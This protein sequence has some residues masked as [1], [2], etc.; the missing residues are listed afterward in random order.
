MNRLIK[1]LVIGMVCLPY[2]FIAA[3]NAASDPNAVVLNVLDPRGAIPPPP[4]NVPSK[5]VTNL[6]GKTVGIYWIGKA[7]GDHFWD[8]VADLMHK[9]YP[10]TKIIKYYT[11]V[12]TV[13]DKMAAKI[14][15]QVDTL[16]YGVGD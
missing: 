1:S 12:F 9:R 7:G 5:R 4:F 6:D 8:G 15:K 3:A 14:A 16:F 10:H 2:F 11:H 13:G